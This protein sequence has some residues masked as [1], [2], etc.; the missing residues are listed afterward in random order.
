MGMLDEKY[1][2]NDKNIPIK[3]AV[4]TMNTLMSLRI[5]LDFIPYLLNSMNKEIF[6]RRFKR[7]CS[8][9]TSVR[10]IKASSDVLS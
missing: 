5:R 10:K 1:D 4:K 3:G 2:D 9:L 7:A 6:L 8:Y